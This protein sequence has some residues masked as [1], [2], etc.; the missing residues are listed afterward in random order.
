MIKYKKKLWIGANSALHTKII[1]AFHSFGVGGPFWD[2]S[3]FKESEQV[4]LVARN[5]I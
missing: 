5:Q 2:T 4:I 1:N 3:Y